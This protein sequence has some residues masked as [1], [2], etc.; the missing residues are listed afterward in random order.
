M[1]HDFAS[2]CTM[3]QD[4]IDQL[5][6]KGNQKIAK[7]NLVSLDT[8]ETIDEIKSH[9]VRLNKGTLADFG[10]ICKKLVVCGVKN[11]EEFGGHPQ[12]RK[13]SIIVIE[14]DSQL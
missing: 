5:S 8:F 4:N 7:E 6:C 2:F 11:S 3:W 10:G 9:F 1:G 12:T 13:H 14:N